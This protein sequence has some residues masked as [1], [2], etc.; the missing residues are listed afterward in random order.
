MKFKTTKKNVLSKA[1]KVYSVGYCDMAELLRYS[2]PIAYTAGIYGW[3]ANVYEIEGVIIVTGYRPFGE[4]VDHELLKVYEQKASDLNSI[5][6]NYKE[7][8][9]AIELLLSEFIAK[10]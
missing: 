2:E 5:P 9:K 6:S 4:P 3:N 8:K 1:C 10:L 7:H